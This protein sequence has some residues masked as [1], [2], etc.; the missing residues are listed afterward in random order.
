MCFFVIFYKINNPVPIVM[1]IP[2]IIVC[3]VGVSFK[4]IKLRM[5]VITT[6]ALSMGTTLDTSPICI[7]LKKNNQDKPVV[8]PESIRKNNEFQDTVKRV[9]IWPVITTIRKA[10]MTTTTVRTAVARFEFTFS[11]P[12]FARMAVKEANNAANNA[13]MMLI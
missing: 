2:P 6:L 4:M 8:K 11:I 3:L 9:F 7:A 10:I 12:I 13:N 5:I 1:R